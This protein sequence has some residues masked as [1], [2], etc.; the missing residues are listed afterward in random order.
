[1]SISS[2]E[3]DVRRRF[4]NQ[5]KK[6]AGFPWMYENHIKLV[7]QEAEILLKEY[8]EA[9]EQVV[10]L[11]SV[12]HD[13]GYLK[14]HKNHE[15]VGFSKAKEVL[16]EHE[17]ELDQSQLE[18]LDEAITE[19]GYSGEPEKLEA[20]IVASADAL[21]HLYPCFWIANSKVKGNNLQEFYDWMENK[22]NKDRK[23]ICLDHARKRFDKK[24]AGYQCL[25]K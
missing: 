14:D 8:P 7:R 25:T 5:D 16:S 20:R 4:N 19:H 10:L 9:D 1:M 13:V 17:I 11:A 22:I 18:I 3:E 6:H 15:E 2:L 12:L 21:A 24:L 23:K